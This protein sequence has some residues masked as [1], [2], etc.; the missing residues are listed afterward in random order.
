MYTYVQHVI[1]KPNQE[2][3]WSSTTNKAD[4][5]G[6]GGQGVCPPPPFSKWSPP[7]F[8]TLMPIQF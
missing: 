1:N 7:L 2:K 4:L 5:G 8:E 6:G 3:I